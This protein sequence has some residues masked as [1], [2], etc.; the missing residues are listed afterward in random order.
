MN[1]KLLYLFFLLSALTPLLLAQNNPY[2]IKDGLYA[3]YQQC[4]KNINSPRVL[5][6]ADT[7]FT[8]AG[9]EG[10]QKA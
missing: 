5:L 1:K 8:C 10:D 3:Y 2:K 7:L 6:M 9:R 4:V